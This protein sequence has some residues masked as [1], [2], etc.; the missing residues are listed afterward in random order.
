[1]N[2]QYTPYTMPFVVTAAVSTIIALYLLWRRWARVT[3][4]VGVILMLAGCI[5]LWAHALELASADLPAKILWDKVQFVG[6]CI[7]PPAWLAYILRFT[8]RERWLSGGTRILLGLVPFITFLLVVTNDA[9]G[10]IW[11]QVWLDTSG[12]FAVKHATAGVGLWVFTVY[13]YGLLLIGTA[14]LIHALFRSGRV[15]RWQGG[16]LVVAVGTIL[17]LSIVEHVFRLTAVRG[18]ELTPLIFGLIVPLIAWCLRR[19]QLLDIMPVTR[20]AIIEDLEDA[21][22]VLDTEGCILDL[23]PAARQLFYSIDSDLLGRPLEKV[24]PLWSERG[25]GSPDRGAA[26]QDVVFNTPEGRQVFD[27]R[28]SPLTDWRGKAV[29]QIVVLRDITRL[30]RRTT[31]LSTLLDV[32]R[33]VSSSLD[34]DQ[35][36][37]LVAE[38]M[39]RA[40][41]ATSAIICTL[42]AES[43]VATVLAECI[44]PHA[45]DAEKISS[46]GAEHTKVNPEL[47]AVMSAG[48][49]SVSHVDDPNL[50]VSDREFLKKIGAQTVLH[51]PLQTRGGVIAYAEVRESRRRRAF[52]AGDMAL[53]QGI[54]QQAAIAIDNAR[55]HTEIER[56]LKEQVAL[57]EA[58]TAI[59]S[60]SLDSK[61]VLSRIAEQ[62]CRAVD[63]TSAYFSG[64][65]PST[66]VAS[67]LAEYISPQACDREQVSDVGVDY[68]EDAADEWIETM[69]SGQH[70]VSHVDSPGLSEVERAQ[71]KE[72]GAK[73]IL[74]IPLLVS[75]KLIGYAEIWESRQ[76]REFT[77][78]EISLCQDI[79]RQAAI[80]LENARLYEQAQEEIAERLQAEEGIKASLREK[81]VLLQEIHH[82]VK[83]NLQVISSLLNLQASQIDSPDILEVFRESQNRIRSMALI[84]E[85]LYEA[86]NL[87]WIDFGTYIRNLTTYLF[88]SYSVDARRITLTIETDEVRLGIDQA[89]PCGLIL[90]ELMSNAL[91]HAFPVG[92]D[93][94]IRVVLTGN[95]D[96]VALMVRDTGVGFPE[97]LDYRTTT[98]LGLQLVNMLVK[99]LNGEIELENENGTSLQVTFSVPAQVRTPLPAAAIPSPNPIP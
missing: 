65:N 38:Q 37:V 35:V 31:Q 86:H 17:L 72:Y 43:M 82:R 78:E 30:R 1:M 48:R 40:L 91:K 92:R 71:M 52:T 33:A 8:R 94:A 66:L 75:G 60:S 90:N 45:C 53:T 16:V 27:V 58:G 32:T 76:R 41:D 59:T 36:L 47:T 15:Y 34:L 19:L 54:T 56:R 93:G 84:H 51:V 6:I 3:S 96:S 80:A 28:V 44:G 22:I 83:N 26:G 88:H 97:G 18:V 29:G 7:I 81:E 39:C 50:P 74:Y 13:A 85:Q 2:W 12:P 57:R 4:R 79:S 64:Y 20:D 99:Q 42:N 5:W 87:A 95:E 77:P 55:F 49:S 9:H 21:L 24:L 62:M 89:V 46:L 67:V 98:S 23:N 69:Q 70:D 10:L 11:R 68:V 25:D 61:Q 63:A 14:F 73:T